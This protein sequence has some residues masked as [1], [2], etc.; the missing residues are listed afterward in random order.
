M[1]QKVLRTGHSLAVVIP[2]QFVRDIAVRV[3][4]PVSVTPDRKRGKI[5]YTFQNATQLPLALPKS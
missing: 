3:G 4:D 2:S 1:K 5:T